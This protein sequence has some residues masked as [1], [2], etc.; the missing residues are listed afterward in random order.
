MGK[1]RRRR[2]VSVGTIVMLLLTALVIA[3][4]AFFLT[5]IA[6]EDLYAK[7]GELFRSLT[8]Q[9]VFAPH[10]SGEPQTDEPEQEDSVPVA[11]QEQPTAIAPSPTPVPAASTFTLAAAG[12]VYAPKVVRQGAEEETDHYDFA[13]VFAGLGTALSEADLAVAT[14]ETTTAGKEAGYGNYN[15]PAQILDALRDAGVDLIALA[16]ERALE[17]GYEGLDLT[18]SELTARGLAY[19]GVNPDGGGVS[20]T[21]MSVGGVQVAVLS[22]TYG[23]SDEGREKTREDSQG[24]LAMLET[25]RVVSDIT[26]A[27]VDGA[28]V[29]IV[30]PHWG[31]KNKTET[32]ENIRTMARAMAEAGADIILGTHPN[33]VQGVERLS[34]ARSDGLTY[35]AVVCYSLG[36]LLTDARTEENTAGMIAHLSVTYDP[37]TRRASLGELTY[38][39]VYIARQREGSASV[40]RVV[41]AQNAQALSA[42]EEGEQEAAR[43]AA[44]IVREA[45]G[46]SEQEE[47]G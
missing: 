5:A 34:V 35:E 8:E 44:E 23:L 42:L 46:Q 27:R 1:K 25:E 7:T 38:T 28:N 30:L 40:Y 6:G 18:V 36:C 47:Q 43:R 21:M 10:S 17:K 11:S 4:C 19:A 15:T 20:A 13:P 14:L 29:V 12:T 24:V 37:V 39:P 22:Y 31:T 41:D 16:T 9:G 45:V 32:P 3:G 2:G 26:K 33:V